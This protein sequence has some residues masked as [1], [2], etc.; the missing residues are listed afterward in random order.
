[1]KHTYLFFIGLSL[2]SFS[3]I[4]SAAGSPWLISPGTTSMQLSYVTQSADELYMGE[5]K[6]PLPNDLT[7][8]TVWVDFAYGIAD[9]MA[10][11]ARLGY[12]DF[13]YSARQD[14]NGTTDTLL[15]LTWRL[16]DEFVH[17]SG[18][19]VA[20]RMGVTLA[21]DYTAGKINSIGDGASGLEASLIVGKIITSKLSIAADAG[22]RYRD[23]GVDNER[24]ASVRGFY[25]LT[26]QLHT[27]VR[28]SVVRANGS[29]DINDPEFAG[30]FTELAEDADIV[31]LGLAYQ[32]ARGY[33]I[34]FGYGQ[35]VDGRN[36]G[37]N[38]IASISFG[39]T[40]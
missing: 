2:F 28:Y 35:V 37:I 40:F 13:E 26:N 15:G 6:R 25:S 10:I 22:Y 14:E 20:L 1:M 4:A 17:D 16:R 38:E 31:E 29:L 24:F 12:S 5:T 27:S 36:T 33:Q 21:G 18:P 39:M 11:D 9:N 7:Q 34:G 23:S 30:N 3:L 19:S 8:T 32:F